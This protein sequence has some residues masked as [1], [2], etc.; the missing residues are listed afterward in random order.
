MITY[1][2]IRR[3][4][5]KTTQM[6]RHV[7]QIAQG[8]K[9]SEYTEFDEKLAK[10][11]AESSGEYSKNPIKKI[12]SWI[13]EF[14]IHIKDERNWLKNNPPQKPIENIKE[15]YEALD[16]VAFQM[17]LAARDA[18]FITKDLDTDV[19]ANMERRLKE[20]LHREQG[21]GTWKK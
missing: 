6:R 1:P 3:A 14:V 9:P 20:Q 11:I 16:K 7:R 13:K 12:S 19:A 2:M 4:V 5:V 10:T 21:F 8:I 18:H 17:P 15:G